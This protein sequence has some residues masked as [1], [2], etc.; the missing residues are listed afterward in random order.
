MATV[1]VSTLTFGALLKRHRRA[2]RMTQAQLAERAG[3]SVVYISMLERGA[4]QPQRTTV[5]LLVDALDLAAEERTAL[6]AAARLPSA[7]LSLRRENGP[8]E[9]A[10]TA[11]LPIGG[12]LGATPTGELVGRTEELATITAILAA[13]AG[14]GALA[15]PGGRARGGQD[16]AGARDHAAGARGAFASSP[17]GATSH[18]R[19]SPTTPSWRRWPWRRRAPIPPCRRSC[20]RTGPRWPGS[21]PTAWRARRRLFNWTT[22]T[23]SS[24][25]SGR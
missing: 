4:R 3:F 14:A 1:S 5:A 24:A 2:A 16:A 8:V 22:I 10:G 17:G 19:V 21:Y 23:R 11:V 12:F 25:S 6:E 15:R 13:G 20:H 18:S 9:D 7:P